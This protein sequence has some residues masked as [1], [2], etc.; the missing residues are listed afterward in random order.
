MAL[1]D[2]LKLLAPELAAET[3]A[4]LDLFLGWASLRV[5]RRVFG[6][7]AD[8]ATLLLTAHMLTRFSADA[9]PAAGGTITQEKV[10][11]I[12]TSY[13]ALEMEGDA[14]FATTAYGAQFAQM[15]RGVSISPM[16]V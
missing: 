4:R 15:R 5:N 10:G 8:L 11:D 9:S 1:R 3:D 12:Q 7:K 14:E 6:A 13:A 16:V 2:D